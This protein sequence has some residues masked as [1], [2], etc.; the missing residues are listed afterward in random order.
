MVLALISALLLSACCLLGRHYG[1]GLH[2]WNVTPN[3]L[4]LPSQIGRITKALYGC[5]LAY[6]TSI[7]FTK[8]SI[9]ATY[10]RIFPSRLLRTTFYLTALI[11]IVFWITSVFC[12]IFTCVP[13]QAAWDYSIEDARCIDILAYFYTVAGVNIA[14]DLLLCFVPLPT[15]WRLQMPKAQR[16]VVCVLFGMGT[17]C[18]FLFPISVHRANRSSACVASILRLIQLKNLTGIDVPCMSLP[19]FPPSIPILIDE[20]WTVGS[21]NWSVIEVGTAIV[22]ASLSSLRPLATKYL[23]NIFS[24]LTQPSEYPHPKPDSPKTEV[25]CKVKSGSEGEK[26]GNSIYIS[27]SF[28]MVVMSGEEGVKGMGKQWLERESQE[29]L[30]R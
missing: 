8:L 10:I 28:E 24:H 1:L 5:Y 6:S 12:I 25:S 21:L 22:C 16:V 11:V 2:L 14:T 26:G 3:L 15:V 23:P 17:L 29:V 18:A 13:I 20:D 30:V 19:V 4:D 27:Q 9:I 7:T